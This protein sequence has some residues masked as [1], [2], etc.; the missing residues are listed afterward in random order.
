M[1][2]MIVGYACCVV[3]GIIIHIVVIKKL[4]RFQNLVV[5]TIPVAQGT[6]VTVT[7]PSHAKGLAQRFLAAL[8]GL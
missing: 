1:L 2:L 4:R 8:P 6:E 5:T 3:P 7:F